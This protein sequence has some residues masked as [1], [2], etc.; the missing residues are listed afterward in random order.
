MSLP[1]KVVVIWD[2]MEICEECAGKIAAELTR[3]VRDRKVA[4]LD[5]SAI[6][7]DECWKHNI[8]RRAIKVE[9]D[10]N[11]VRRRG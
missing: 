5:I 11:V 9:L 10:P 7:C 3:I 2:R 6:L 8:D 4:N 1:V